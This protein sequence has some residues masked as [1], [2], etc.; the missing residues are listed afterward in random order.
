MGNPALRNS[1]KWFGATL[2][3]C[4]QGHRLAGAD[5]TLHAQALEESLKPIRALTTGTNFGWNE[6]AKQFIWAPEFQFAPVSGGDYG[7]TVIWDG[8]Q[9]SLETTSPVISLAPI[10]S[11][12]PVGKVR[13]QAQVLEASQEKALPLVGERQFHRGAVFNGPYGKPLLPYGESARVALDG[14]I[15]EPFVQYWRTHGRPDP[16]YKLY[17]Y[18][19]KQ[20]GC[21][22]TACTLYASRKLKPADADEALEIAR[23][24]ADFLLSVSE[25]AGSPLEYF[26]PTYYN[27]APTKRENDGWTMMMSGA[28]AGNGLLDLYGVSHDRTYLEAA[29]RIA[30]TYAKTQRPDGTWPLKVENRN[31]R[32]LADI[33]LIPSAVITF[34]DRLE[35]ETHEPI[36]RQTRDRACAW[37]L[38]N[39]ARTFNWQAQFDDAKLRGPYQN[40]GKHEACEFATYLFTHTNAAPGSV[41]LAEE[42]L[43]FAEDQF[44]VWEQPPR[45]PTRDPK[46]AAANWFTPC[47]LE[48]HA[49]FEPIS[50]SSAFMIFTY[51]RAFQATG[52][53]LYLAKAESLANAL[54]EAQQYH[55]GRYPTRMVREDLAYW[56][57]STINTVRAMKLL[58]EEEERVNAQAK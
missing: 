6:Q 32:P 8:G 7:L 18:L 29:R 25:P 36:Y 28:E 52:K 4:A 35:A 45:L 15:H 13:L 47:S 58:A 54:T 43:R 44:V 48:Q 37:I 38:K 55:H 17:R 16:D 49:M 51:I 5:A 23:R 41:A 14:V 24:C 33:D 10:W 42:I 11:G 34:L 39:P 57:N 20:S 3:F 9:R 22:I 26:P 46:L 56:V 53:R 30:A 27:A 21:L 2:L 31:A 1:C 40:L 12:I 19:A 50:G